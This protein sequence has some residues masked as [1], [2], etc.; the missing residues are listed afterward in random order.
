VSLIRF[1]IVIIGDDLLNGFK[2][3]K[4][5][6][7]NWFYLG[8]RLGMMLKTRSVSLY[9]MLKILACL[10]VFEEVVSDESFIETNDSLRSHAIILD[11]QYE[12]RA[13]RQI[14]NA[15]QLSI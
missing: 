7:Q 3:M 9:R 11:Q 4:M 5:P 6:S 1:S 14:D 2:T 13:A 12:E 8:K 10:I 15:S